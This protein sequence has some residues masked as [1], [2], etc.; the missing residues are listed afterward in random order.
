L[1]HQSICH[2]WWG[3]RQN[4]PDH[5]ENS[6]E[7]L[8]RH[9]VPDGPK[10]NLGCGPV[11]P[12]G[13]INIDGSNRA[14][15]AAW[16]PWLDR[17]MTRLRLIPPTEFGP[18]VTIHNLFKPL[19]FRPN[20]VSCI[21]AGEVWEHFEYA[22]AVRLTKECFKALASG[23]VLRVCVP[24]GVEFWTRYLELFRGEMALPR[25][26]RSAQSLHDHVAM[27]Y[28]EICTRKHLFGSMG[29]THKWQFDE[30]QLIAL[31]ESV[32]FASVERMGFHQSRAPGI[33]MVERSDFLIVEGVKPGTEAADY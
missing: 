32:G 26:E 12:D 4:G 1:A 33:E 8:M 29:H 23:G 24:D 22:D 11:Q 6:L 28:R 15:L 31:F 9:T 2:E 7:V 20:S 18:H 14:K 17:L 3:K 25:S 16:L 19:P 30:V 10:V 5:A 21:Y 27:Y 13:W